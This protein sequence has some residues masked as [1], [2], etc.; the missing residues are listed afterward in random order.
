MKRYYTSLTVSA[1]ALLIATPS[2]FADQKS[3]CL[4][5]DPKIAIPACSA[6]IDGKMIPDKTDLVSYF[7]SSARSY[8]NTDD[9]PHTEADAQRAIDL[10]SKNARAVTFARALLHKEFSLAAMTRLGVK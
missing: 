2:V 8:F 6:L 4:Q 10:N 5:R 3:D 7:A 9:K 1:A